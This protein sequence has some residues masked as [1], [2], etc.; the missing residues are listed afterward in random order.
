MFPHEGPEISAGAMPKCTFP[1]CCCDCAFQF[2]AFRCLSSVQT[3]PAGLIVDQK[4]KKRI[5]AN[6]TTRN[7]FAKKAVGFF[8][9]FAVR[10]RSW[11]SWQIFEGSGLWLSRYP[12]VLFVDGC[13]LYLYSTD[14]L[15]RG[16]GG[17]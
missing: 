5:M 17:K 14:G 12:I 2:R 8:K 4:E 7:L 10:V 15:S 11:V 9:A 6:R 3:D 13:A 1:R 16:L